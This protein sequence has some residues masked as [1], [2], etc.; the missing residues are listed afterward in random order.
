MAN[1]ELDTVVSDFNNVKPGGDFSR[2]AEELR[3]L[4]RHDQAHWKQNL[5]ELN[6]RVDMR[7]LGFSEDF[8]IAGV[9]D[10]GKFLTTSAD[11]SKA[12]VRDRTHMEI[13]QEKANG[14]AQEKWGSRNFTA[15]PD[16]SGEYHTKKGDTL[17]S[18][19]KDTLTQQLGHAPTNTE[20]ANQVA[21]IAKANNMKDANRMGSEATIKIPSPT[22]HGE[23][24]ARQ[25]PNGDANAPTIQPKDGTSNPLAVPGLGSDRPDAQDPSVKHRELQSRERSEGMTTEKYTGALDDGTTG[26]FG[27]DRTTFQAERTVGRDGKLVH[28]KVNYDGS[29]ASL[30]IDDGKGGK[31]QFDHVKSVETS[32]NS[33]S[34]QYE[35]MITGSDGKQYRAT[36]G[37]DGKVLSVK[38]LSSVAA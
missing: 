9:T 30:S 36:T 25:A 13:E 38:P 12:Q 27:M 37:A 15:N 5:A 33:V 8:Q 4:Q 22:P 20:V 24:P 29:G 7:K 18:V 14:P 31:Q 11:G 28:S 3:D 35:T 26:L 2:V 23:L 10:Q 1:R 6:N 32:F 19:A 17:W 21:A 16:G 34:G